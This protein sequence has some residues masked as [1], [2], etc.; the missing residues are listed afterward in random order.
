MS[1]DGLAGKVGP[2]VDGLA[3]VE[4]VVVVAAGEHKS[5]AWGEAAR[6]EIDGGGGDALAYGVVATGVAL[7]KLVPSGLG[8]MAPRREDLDVVSDGGGG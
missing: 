4:G 3:S 6:G 5:R 1:G 7:F 2:V 8:P